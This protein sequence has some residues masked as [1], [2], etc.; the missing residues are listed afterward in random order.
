MKFVPRSILIAVKFQRNQNRMAKL[1]YQRTV[2][3]TIPKQTHTQNISDN[4]I[5]KLA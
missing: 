3:T 1:K 4:N 5:F 2:D